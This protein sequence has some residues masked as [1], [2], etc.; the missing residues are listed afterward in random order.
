M[1]LL[2]SAVKLQEEARDWRRHLHQ[3]PELLYDVDGTAAFIAEKLR[4]FGVDEVVEGI[5]RTGVVGLIRG[6]GEGGRVIGLRA[7][8][9]A[10]PL[11]E[12]SGKAWA[13][14]VNGR[15][16]ACG[17]DGHMAMLLGAAK[18][19]A[20]T[21]NFKG[22]VALIFQPAEEGGA[23]GKA[24]IDDGL[25]ERFAIDEIYGMHNFPG[26]PVGTFAI[27]PGPIMAATDEFRIIVR[28][29]G[30]H[31]AQPDKTIDP[32]LIGSQI[33]QALQVIVSRNIGPVTPLVVSVTEFHAGFAHNIIPDDAELGGTVRSFT[34]ESRDLAEARIGAIATGIAAAHGAEAELRY[35]R[36]YP[37]TVN[38][39][40]ETLHAAAAA[41]DVAGEASVDTDFAPWTAAEDFS[42]MLEARPG[43]FIMLGNGDTAGL[44]NP[45]YDFD[46]EALPYG[47]SY[48]VRLAESRLSA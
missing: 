23:G 13:S 36:N 29:Q 30:G 5:G 3:Y 21:R 26:R 24:M 38:H 15:M 46:D 41:I 39:P 43:A 28:G 47:I 37:P 18:H 31:A 10:L 48:W 16:H 1:P 27:R 45:A 14:T 40:D 33:V 20:E 11:V 32:L 42:Y 17:H 2:N 8:M 25:M 22:A 7:D 4:S 44:H 35:H 12:K 6:R 9:D 19:L 34:P